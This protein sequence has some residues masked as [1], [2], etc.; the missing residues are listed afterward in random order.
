M[1][2][3]RGSHPDELVIDVER[4]PGARDAG[5]YQAQVRLDTRT[6]RMVDRG[7]FDVSREYYDIVGREINRR[8]ADVVTDKR[9]R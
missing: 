6:G 5:I 9:R 1:S 3:R 2:I 8:V 7:G 4:L